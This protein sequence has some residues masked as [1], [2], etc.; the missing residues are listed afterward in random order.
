LSGHGSSCLDHQR[1][2]QGEP[3]PD[4]QPAAANTPALITALSLGKAGAKPS[5]QARVK[6]A[7]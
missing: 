2:G 3:E 4:G 1:D 6:I 5:S 7:R